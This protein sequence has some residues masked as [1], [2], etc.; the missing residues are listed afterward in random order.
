VLDLGSDAAKNDHGVGV[1]GAHILTLRRMITSP[2]SRG[3]DSEV[4]AQGWDAVVAHSIDEIMAAEA[5]KGKPR[6]V[7]KIAH[8][9]WAPGGCAEVGEHPRGY[10]CGLWTL[11]HVPSKSP[12]P[13]PGNSACTGS[14]RLISAL[15]GTATCLFA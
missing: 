7:G 2:A 14:A 3:V 4:T 15:T 8:D 13:R 6:R 12:C 9:S 5:K 10:T 11:I 1:F